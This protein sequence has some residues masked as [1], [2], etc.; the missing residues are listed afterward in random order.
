M[1]TESR[2]RPP[3]AERLARDAHKPM[4]TGDEHGAAARGQQAAGHP[5]KR[6]AGSPGAPGRAGSLLGIKEIRETF[7]LGRSPAHRLT[8]RLDFPAAVGI[9]PVR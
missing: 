4:S 7:R 3:P 9:F 8:M 6:I 2:P 1:D 5:A